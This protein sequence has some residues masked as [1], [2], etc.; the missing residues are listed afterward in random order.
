M[1]HGN[2][3][4]ILEDAQ[5]DFDTFLAQQD[6]VQAQDVIDNLRDIGFEHEADILRKAY[7]KAQYE[8]TLPPVEEEPTDDPWAV[9]PDKGLYS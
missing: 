1:S 9:E 4:L 6:W 5:S 2:N 7:L 3:V 8:S